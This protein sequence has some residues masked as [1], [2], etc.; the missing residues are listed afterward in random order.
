MRLREPGGE[1]FE[2][3]F[4]VAFIHRTVRHAQAALTASAKRRAWHRH[5]TRLFEEARGNRGRIGASAYPH[6]REEATVD[7]RPLQTRDVRNTFS[8]SPAAPRELLVKAARIVPVG[9]Y[10]SLGGDL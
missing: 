8:D 5:D 4:E 10:G 7:R 9:C 6:E 1:T 3:F 2:R